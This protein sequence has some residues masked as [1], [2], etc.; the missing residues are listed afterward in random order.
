MTDAAAMMVSEL[1]DRQR[2]IIGHPDWGGR[3]STGILSFPSW[4]GWPKGSV[5]TLRALERAGIVSSHKHY[6]RRNSIVYWRLTSKGLALHEELKEAVS[7]EVREAERASVEQA[8][9]DYEARLRRQIAADVSKLIERIERGAIDERHLDR[10][11]AALAKA[12][13]RS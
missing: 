2:V 11:R 13:G 10:L 7:Q 3:E 1:T 9:A 4:R 12:E 6:S 8:R 5:S